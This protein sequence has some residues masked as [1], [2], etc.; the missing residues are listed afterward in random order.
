MRRAAAEA[1][2]VP[3]GAP[4]IAG[5]RGPR[6]PKE[7]AAGKPRVASRDRDVPSG[8]P[9]VPEKHREVGE[10]DRGARAPFLWSLSFG[11]K[12]K[13]PGVRGGAPARNPIRSEAALRHYFSLRRQT[14][15]TPRFAPTACPKLTPE[16]QVCRETR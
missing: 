12:R 2:R 3:C 14:V 6:P 1:A 9:P 10:A 7:G 5:R 13:G 15:R 4:S 16:E 11:A 8:D